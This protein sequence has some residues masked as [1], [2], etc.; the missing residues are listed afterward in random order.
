MTDGTNTQ[1]RRKLPWG[2]I[3]CGLSLALNLLVVGLLLGAALG[4]DGGR[5]GPAARH[6]ERVSLGLGAQIHAL[7]D[8]SRERVLAAA[9]ADGKLDK[10][11][12]WAALRAARREVIEALAA[13]PFDPA[14]AR[15]ALERARG[16]ALAPT[17]AIHEA[18]VAEW[19]TLSPEERRAALERARTQRKPWRGHGAEKGG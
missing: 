16:S 18:F 1:A 9:A 12:R 10:R 15:A 4:F 3:L 5:K 14:R 7:P 11:S 2:R 8:A 17:R 6:L 19:S 13:E